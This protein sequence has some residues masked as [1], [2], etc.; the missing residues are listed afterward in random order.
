M[1]PAGSRCTFAL[2]RNWNFDCAYLTGAFVDDD[3]LFLL[4]HVMLVA[5]EA[6]VSLEGLLDGIVELVHGLG[7]FAPWGFG[8]ADQ[9]PARLV[10][11]ELLL[12]G[13]EGEML[14]VL[15]LVSLT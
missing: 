11:F 8:I 2:I 1:T 14:L 5:L 12:L 4:D 13:I 6:V 15:H 3:D 10:Q 9:L 7:V